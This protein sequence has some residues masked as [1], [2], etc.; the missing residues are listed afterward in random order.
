MPKFI[1]I[2]KEQAIKISNG[3]QENELK[4]VQNGK[5]EVAKLH[6]N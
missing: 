1:K 6:K 5:I 3:F 4:A 2:Y